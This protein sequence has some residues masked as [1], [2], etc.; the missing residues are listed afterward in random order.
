[1]TRYAKNLGG[2]APMVPPGY[3]YTDVEILRYLRKAKAT[4]LRKAKAK[5]RKQDDFVPLLYL[6]LLS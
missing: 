6:R 2:M 5:I 1:M 4:V 3:A